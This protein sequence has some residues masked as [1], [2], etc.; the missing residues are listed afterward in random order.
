MMPLRRGKILPPFPRCKASKKIRPCFLLVG[1]SL[2]SVQAVILGIMAR[3]DGGASHCVYDSGI[4]A[5]RTALFAG[6]K[7]GASE[8]RVPSRAPAR[9]VNRHT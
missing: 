5:K 6:G 4:A 8:S 7:A 3:S 1:Q 2:L 9:F